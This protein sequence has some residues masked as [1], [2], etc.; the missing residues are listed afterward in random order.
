MVWAVILFWFGTVSRVV[1]VEETGIKAVLVQP[2]RWTH[3]EAE[4]EKR[5]WQ[6]IH[7]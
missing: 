3:K 4:E 2:L 1:G 5:L 7:S 6:F